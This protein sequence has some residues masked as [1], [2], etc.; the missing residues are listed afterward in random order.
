MTLYLHKG[1]IIGALGEI[2]AQAYITTKN[3]KGKIKDLIEWNDIQGPVGRVCICISVHQELRSAVSDLKSIPGFT[4]SMAEVAKKATKNS[5][6]KNPTDN[7]RDNTVGDHGPTVASKIFSYSSQA[8]QNLTA[9]H[10]I[11][12]GVVID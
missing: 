3:H 8:F 12:R 10:T 7:N 4:V 2:L 6:D 5:E 11:H 1:D 9:S